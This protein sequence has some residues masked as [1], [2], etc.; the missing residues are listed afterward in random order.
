MLSPPADV[1]A[2]VHGR[3]E[4]LEAAFKKTIKPQAFQEMRKPSQFFKTRYEEGAKLP[5]RWHEGHSPCPLF[6]SIKQWDWFCKGDVNPY[7]RLAI[8]SFLM[9]H[10]A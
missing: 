6:W 8:R 5:E 4:G 7:D 3:I 9:H 2:W 1:N 10:R